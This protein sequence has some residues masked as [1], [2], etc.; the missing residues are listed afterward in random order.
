[1]KK[2]LIFS[3]FFFFLTLLQ[4]SFFIHFSF[5]GFYL[6]FIII[7]Q[8]LITIFEDLK[9]NRAIYL[10]LVSG[11]FWD[12]FSAKPIGFGILILFSITFILKIFLRKYVRIEGFSKF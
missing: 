12:I 6:N 8:I 4:T 2:F 1:M 5:F 3:L 7:A 9:E 11:F 10:S